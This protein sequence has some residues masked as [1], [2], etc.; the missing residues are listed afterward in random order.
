M[1]R[2]TIA[3]SQQAPLS[4]EGARPVRAEAPRPEGGAVLRAGNAAQAGP[5]VAVGGRSSG[6]GGERE[7]NRLCLTFLG[8]LYGRP[9]GRQGASATGACG[10]GRTTWAPA[11]RHD[12]R[13]APPKGRGRPAAQA[14]LRGQTLRT[15]RKFACFPSPFSPHGR[16]PAG[17]SWRIMVGRGRRAQAGGGAVPGSPL[18]MFPTQFALDIRHPHNAKEPCMLRTRLASLALAASLGPLAGCFG[19]IVPRCCPPAAPCCPSACCDTGYGAPGGGSCCTAHAGLGVEEGPMLVPPGV[20]GPPMPPAGA[21]PFVPGPEAG[22]PP[23]PNP[24]LVPAPTMAP[25]S[26]YVPH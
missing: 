15:S 19:L 9:Q 14:Q 20:G 22:L 13:P 1:D 25:T 10:C 21:V 16:L 18:L 6:P 8:L 12:A 23:A 5:A 26:P 3:G 4:A 24:R 11:A 17:H 2:E 7:E